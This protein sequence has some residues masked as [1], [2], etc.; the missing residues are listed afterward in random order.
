VTDARLT[1]LPAASAAPAVPAPVGAGLQAGGGLQAVLFDMDGLLIDSE[2]LW[3]QVE[4]EVM[5]QLGGTWAEADQR[6]LL[7]SSLDNAVRYFLE[8]AAGPA[9]PAQV[10]D[11]M[12]RGIID[13]VR[14][15][16]V[17]VMPGAA[18]L[19]GEVAASGLCHA[20]VTS[21]QRLF[22]DAVLART[23]LRFPMLVCGNDVRRG[24]PDPE[25]YLLAARRL[26]VDPARCLVLEDSAAGITAAEAAGCFVVAVPT[27]RAVEPR[28]GRLVVPSL[29]GI[30][31]GRLRAAW[32]GWERPGGP[33]GSSG[34]AAVPRWDKGTAPGFG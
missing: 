24:K 23:G 17:T 11:W 20:L 2:P 13:R 25:P 7:G 15:Q 27:L 1:D 32:D 10:A 30:S 9:D 6:E 12:I 16:G 21:S 3:F 4:T 14:E 5:A 18:E 22:V 26:G 31:L 8:R 29:R 33:S 19:V 34:P 28:P